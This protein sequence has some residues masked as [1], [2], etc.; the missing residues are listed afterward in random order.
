MK[1]NNLENKI[2]VESTLIHINQYNTEEQFGDIK[3]IVI[4]QEY[5]PLT[6]S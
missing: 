6:L 1:V 4:K 5:K 3:H 2:S